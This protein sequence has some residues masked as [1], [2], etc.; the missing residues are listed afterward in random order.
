MF[1]THPQAP[2]LLSIP[3]IGVRT[4]ARILTE[5]GD[6]NRFPTGGHL[7]AYAGLAPVTRQSGSSLNGETRSRRGNHRL[8]NAMWL[9][10]FCSSTT[11]P[12]ATTTPANARK[13]SSTTPPSSASPA[14]AA[15]SSTPCSAQGSATANHQG[16][17]DRPPNP[18][19]HLPPKPLDKPIGTH[20]PA[21]RPRHPSQRW[22]LSSRLDSVAAAPPPAPPA[23]AWAGPARFYLV[24]RGRG[25]ARQRGP[26]FLD[27]PGGKRK[28]RRRRDGGLLSSGRTT[29][30]EQQVE[31]NIREQ[32]P[33]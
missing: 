31:N 27:S 17:Q 12:R 32:Q 13:A 19:S 33:R 25:P 16:R 6:I 9:S 5:I 26:P 22:P 3:G 18:K 14:A 7:A 29:T 24:G 2:V 11:T 4:G 28:I 8:K 20:P 10:A 21:P 30:R 15:T 1:T 23:P